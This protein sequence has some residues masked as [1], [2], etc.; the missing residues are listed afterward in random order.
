MLTRIRFRNFKRFEEATVELGSPT[1]LIGPNNSGK[2]TALQ[3]LALWDYGRRAWS[4]RRSGQ[5]SPKKRPGVPLNRR[6]LLWLPVPSAGLL[7]RDSHVRDTVRE[8][9]RS[10]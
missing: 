7:W 8:N 2:T 10:R 6:D 3:A 9:G 4:S 1:V 5:D